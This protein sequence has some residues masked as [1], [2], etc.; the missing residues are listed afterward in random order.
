LAD[1]VGQ[2]LPACLGKAIEELFGAQARPQLAAALEG[3]R[4]GDVASTTV[5]SGT[6]QRVQVDFTPLYDPSGFVG[7]L[8]EISPVGTQERR[9]R[10][11]AAAALSADLGSALRRGDLLLHFQPVVSVR[12]E[13]VVGAEVLLRWQHETAGLL[14]AAQFVE[15]VEGTAAFGEVSE[16]VL[17]QACAQA[18]ALRPWWMS[19]NLSAAQLTDKRI[20][21]V[22]AAALHEY[23][24]PADALLLEVT[25]SR[26]TDDLSSAVETLSRLREM[27]LRVAL[28]DF[29][30]GYSSLLYLRELPVTELKIDRTFVAGL[31]ANADDTAIVAAAVSLAHQIG[32]EATAVGVETRAQLAH[33]RRLGCHRGQGYLWSAPLS[34]EDMRQ[35]HRDPSLLRRTGP[36]ATMGRPVPI[37]APADPEESPTAH[38]AR[39]QQ[40][41]ASPA[42]IAAVL[43]NL[44]YVTPHGSRWHANSVAR[45]IAQ[46]S[47]PALAL[48]AGPEDH[49]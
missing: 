32:I 38:I 34:V 39:L 35:L 49:R 36:G 23:G 17:R 7:A 22:A 6:G 10:Q 4:G 40:A 20:L 28:D 27:G 46:R 33:L 13:Q 11:P 44:G 47:F 37:A 42:T 26:I 14:V 43:N 21:A 25:E 31:G 19:V 15:Q 1:A 8:V 18:R 16:W 29:G 45:L 30:T 41:G 12:D 5:I 24:L 2:P 3:C 48:D 9:R